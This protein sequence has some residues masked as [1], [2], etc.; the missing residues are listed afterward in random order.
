MDIQL[1]KAASQEASQLLQTVATAVIHI[2][3]RWCVERLVMQ[4]KLFDN[5]KV[6]S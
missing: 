2:M 6:K 5:I 3:Y 1:L 4:L